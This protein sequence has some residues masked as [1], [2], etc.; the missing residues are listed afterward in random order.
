MMY[1]KIKETECVTISLMTVFH[2]WRQI[3]LADRISQGLETS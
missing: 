3:S 2:R 1:G